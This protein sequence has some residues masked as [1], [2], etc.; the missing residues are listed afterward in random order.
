MRIYKNKGNIAIAFDYDQRVIDIVK[1]LPGRK[2][3]A[4]R[5][6][7]LVPEHFAREVVEALKPLG[8]EVEKEILDLIKQREDFDLKTK[9]PLFEYQKEGVKFLMKEKRCLLGDEMGI[10]KSLQT[11]V[12]CEELGLERVLICTLASLK[13][14]MEEEIKKWYPKTTTIVI[15]GSKRER[16]KQYKK[17]AKYIITS[18]ELV[19]QDVDVLKEI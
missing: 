15:H 18:Y 4:N 17:K 13:W 8:F 3:D 9:L 5:K 19:R 14:S 1:N 11:L 16:M 12:A 10:G 6:E 2:Y 7:W